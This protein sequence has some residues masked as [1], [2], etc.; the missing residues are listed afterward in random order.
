LQG[1]I[2][3]IIDDPPSPSTTLAFVNAVYFK[4]NWEIPFVERVTRKRTFFVNSNESLDVQMMM[5][6]MTIPFADHKDYQIAAVP[7]KG[8][9]TGFYVILPKSP[10]AGER[11]GLL[12]LQ[13]LLVSMLI[14]TT[15]IDKICQDLFLISICIQ[16]F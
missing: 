12:D 3:S 9:R 13:V 10:N 11:T 4:G 8:N 7:Y 14:R 5:N 6:L 1:K 16:N 2:N 15:L